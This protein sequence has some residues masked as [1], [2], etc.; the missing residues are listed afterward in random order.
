MSNSS[1]ESIF[2]QALPVWSINATNERFW[3]SDKVSGFGPQ[4]WPSVATAT[5]EP[6]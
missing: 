4:G 5:E 2:D 3:D 1:A 6:Q